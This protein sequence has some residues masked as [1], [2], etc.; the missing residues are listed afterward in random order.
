MPG[1]RASAW[2]WTVPIPVPTIPTPRKTA[3][4]KTRNT[5]STPARCCWP[6]GASSG[7]A[8]GPSATAC[9]NASWTCPYSNL[10]AVNNG[11]ARICSIR[12][13]I[14]WIARALWWTTPF[15]PWILRG[16]WSGRA[17]TRRAPFW[18]TRTGSAKNA[19]PVWPWPRPGRPWRPWLRK[20]GGH[21]PPSRGL[22]LGKRARGRGLNGAHPAK[23]GLSSIWRTPRR[24]G[25]SPKENGSADQNV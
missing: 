16:K 17:C 3:S 6:R 9:A 1:K 15:A 11:I 24:S 2:S 12:P 22:A 14:P 19:G 8:C 18:P 20:P 25:A 10:Q 7:A 4:R 5:W 23:R 13:D 21:H